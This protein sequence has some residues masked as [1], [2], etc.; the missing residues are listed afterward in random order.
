MLQWAG[1]WHGSFTFKKAHITL[2]F[3]NSASMVHDTQCRVYT[4][5]R[6]VQLYSD[7]QGAMSSRPWYAEPSV[8]QFVLTRRLHSNIYLNVKFNRESIVS[9]LAIH[10]LDSNR[11]ETKLDIVLIFFY[12]LY[13]YNPVL[14]DDITITMGR[15]KF[16]HH[17]QNGWKETG[18][19]FDIP[20]DILWRSTPCATHHYTRKMKIRVFPWDAP[21]QR[22]RRRTNV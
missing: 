10:T 2:G 12:L 9:G 8:T 21:K 20:L 19:P 7:M 5:K 16:V 22:F 15:R 13:V 17:A 1:R 14:T 4:W 11:K 18:T 6:T 3:I